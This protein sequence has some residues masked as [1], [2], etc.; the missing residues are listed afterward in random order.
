MS[1]LA[2]IAIAGLAVSAVSFAV[3][4]SIGARSGNV[5]VNLHWFDDL[6]DCKTNHATATS[7]TLDWNGGDEVSVSVPANLHYHPGQGTQL[8][9]TGDPEL[10]SHVKVDDDEIRMD[11][12]HHISHHNRIDITLPGNKTFRE[13]N[14][15]GVVTADLNDLN[16]PELEVAMAGASDVTATGKTD[17]LTVSLA[18][19]SD[20]HAKDL[21]AKKVEINIAGHGNIETS[22]QDSVDISIAGRGDVKLYS[23][24]KH[25]E[26]SILGSGNIEHL[27]PKG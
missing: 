15:K 23:E 12:S 26:S 24:P 8:V 16:Q 18:G 1:K 10:L 9:M 17:K 4:A 20:V 6:G 2:V 7:R 5:D 3:V 19:K 21:I 27:A 14:L 13:V 11:C 25:V 22:P